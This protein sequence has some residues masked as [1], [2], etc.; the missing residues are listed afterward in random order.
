MVPIDNHDVSILTSHEMICLRMCQLGP[1]CI[2]QTKQNHSTYVVQCPR[3]MQRQLARGLPPP[4]SEPDALYNPAAVSSR[5]THGA[6]SPAG[7]VL[8]SSVDGVAGGWSGAPSAPAPASAPSAGPP[9]SASSSSCPAAPSWGGV[10]SRR[11]RSAEVN[12]AQCFS[13]VSSGHVQVRM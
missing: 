2:C 13:Q 11:V 7:G 1:L 8:G 10:R 12:T 9:E 4:P 5:H 3:N 6:S